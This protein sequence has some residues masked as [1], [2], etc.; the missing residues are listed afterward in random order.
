MLFTTLCAHFVPQFEWLFMR[1]MGGDA[2]HWSPGGAVV[3]IAVGDETI[4]EEA[5]DDEALD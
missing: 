3:D 5:E 4:V 1:F 2:S